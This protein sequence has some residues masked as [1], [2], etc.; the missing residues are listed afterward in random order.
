MV[1][2]NHYGFIICYGNYFCIAKNKDICYNCL[3]NGF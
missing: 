3:N 1:N 2:R